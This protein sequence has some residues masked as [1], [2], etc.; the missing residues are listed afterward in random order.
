MNYEEKI[1]N[2]IEFI[3]EY[4]PL[5]EKY[6]GYTVCFSGGK[7]SQVL[8]DLF[9]KANVK[10]HAVYN[11][12]TNDPPHNVYFIRKHYPN[13]EF[14][15]P[16]Q[17]FLQ[18]IEK[19]A[20]LP[21]MGKRFC[22][23]FLKEYYGKGFVA[24][25]VRREESSKRAEY[26]PIEFIS[27]SNTI[28]DEKKMNK[29]RKVAFRPILEWLEWEIWQYI[30]DNGIPVNPCYE[31]Y[32]RVGCMLCPYAPAKN[33]VSY[34][35]KYPKLKKNF[36]RTIQRI[37]DKGYMKEFKPTAEQ[38]FEWWLSN[39]STDKFFRQLRIEFQPT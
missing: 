17:N 27:K 5:A 23:R 32:N 33:V 18:L 3:R 20:M 31:E 7:D 10:Y 24:T 22:C 35:E 12:T 25:G 21:T 16:K 2:S 9:E 19:N 39:Q 13:V 1:Q 4:A 36:L 8:L 15:L 38:T 11:H 34:L 26:Q 14:I 30:E 37:L 6:G 28:F 29:R